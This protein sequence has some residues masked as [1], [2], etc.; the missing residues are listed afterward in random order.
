MKKKV[1]QITIKKIGK[2]Y[3][4]CISGTPQELKN[5]WSSADLIAKKLR[6]KYGKGIY[7]SKK[8]KMCSINFNKK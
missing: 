7:C 1:G 3:A 2:K 6:K 8:K 5:S 4:V